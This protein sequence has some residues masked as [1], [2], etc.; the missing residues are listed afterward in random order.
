MKGVILSSAPSNMLTWLVFPSALVILWLHSE[1]VQE[2]NQQKTYPTPERVNRHPPSQL[3]ET[4][5]FGVRHVP[6]LT[7]R[8]RNEA[9]GLTVYVLIAPNSLLQ[10]ASRGYQHTSRT[11]GH[12]AV[13]HESQQPTAQYISRHSPLH[14]PQVRKP[15][16]VLEPFFC[17]LC[18][19]GSNFEQRSIG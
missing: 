16:N 1:L 7:D 6:A 3:P 13:L 12:F 19:A 15:D 17:Y 11:Q 14:A 10:P 8:K 2:V 9:V 18:W 4:P 5:C